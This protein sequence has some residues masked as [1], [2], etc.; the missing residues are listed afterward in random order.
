MSSVNTNV[1][2]LLAQ[3]FL[4]SNAAEMSI[5]PNRVP[6][7][8]AVEEPQLARHGASVEEVAAN[9]DHDINR[10]GLD[11]LAPHQRLIPPGARRLG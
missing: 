8:G 4:R 7:L 5:T 9:I 2:A 10:A 6:L 11:H 3:K 1:G